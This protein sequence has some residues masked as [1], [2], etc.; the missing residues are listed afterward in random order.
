MIMSDM[1]MCHGFDCPVKEKCKRFTSKP[2]ELWQ[3]YFL[4]PPY[5]ITD[6][7]FECNMFWGDTQDAIMK[8]L[9]GIVTGKDGEE[10]PE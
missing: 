3:A 7:V 4:N 6:N 8:Q 5:T 1:T 9:M 10:L 2:S